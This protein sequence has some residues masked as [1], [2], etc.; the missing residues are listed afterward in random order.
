MHLQKLTLTTVGT[1]ALIVDETTMAAVESLST[2]QKP[3]KLIWMAGAGTAK[4]IG[5]R[6]KHQ[7]E[8]DSLFGEANVDFIDSII[9]WGYDPEGYERV[10][11]DTA[12]AL[13]SGQKVF[14]AYHSLGGVEGAEILKQIER[15]NPEILNDETL[16]NLN[17][18][19]LSIV[20][21]HNNF[22]EAVRF[23]MR[24]RKLEN[25]IPFGI[26]SVRRGID[27]LAVLPDGKF[28]DREFSV[29]MQRLF[30]QRLNRHGTKFHAVSE[31]NPSPKEADLTEKERKALE[32]IDKKIMTAIE[33]GDVR[34]VFRGLCE[35]SRIGVG[36]VH[37]LYFGSD[38]TGRYAAHYKKH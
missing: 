35:R 20:G 13:K 4:P 14:H 9:S 27:S 23:M 10:A 11:E 37:S 29:G 5:N 38:E 8:S 1:T 25:S 30:D 32:R 18:I 12:R 19:L 21:G 17:I 31:Q 24:L 26:P 15:N 28:E 7:L 36:A 6:L 16:G 34:E 2:S 22:Q 33:K 3:P